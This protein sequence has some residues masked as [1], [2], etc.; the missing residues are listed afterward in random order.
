MEE[1][2][3]KLHSNQIG[4]PITIVGEVKK[5]CT[6]TIKIQEAAFQCV[7]CGAIIRLPQ[8][9]QRSRDTGFYLEVDSIKPCE[10]EKINE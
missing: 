1:S 2:I 4:K 9:K 6:S 8:S 5:V 10:G 7:R 3:Y